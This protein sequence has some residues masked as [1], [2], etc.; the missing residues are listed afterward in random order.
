MYAVKALYDGLNFKPKQ[1]IAIKEEYEVIITFIEPV[2][3]TTARPSFEL[4]CMKGKII[5]A[6]GHDWF[7][8][9]ESFEEYM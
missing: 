3:K 1:P 2:R 5:E 6:D 7:E 4:G 9:L 8:P